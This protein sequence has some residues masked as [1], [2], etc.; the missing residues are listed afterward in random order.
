MARP[1]PFLN[2]LKD[3]GFLPLRLPR[4]DVAPLNMVQQHDKDLNLMGDLTSA[5]VP[6]AGVLPPPI[7]KD[8]QSANKLA[9]QKSSQVKLNIGL[10]ILGNIL[11]ALTGQN[12]GVSA[13]FQRASTLRFEFDDVMIDKVDAIKLD[14]FLSQ[15]DIN[16]A[17]RSIHDSLID[18]T[19]G[20]ITAVAKTKKYVVSA[21]KDD[22]TQAG[23]DVPVIQGVAGG[24]LKVDSSGSSNSE[25]TFE[26]PVPVAFGVQGVHISFSQEGKFTVFDPFQVGEGAVREEIKPK[27][28]VVPVA[29]ANLTSSSDSAAAL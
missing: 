6:H 2:L 18:G 20:V 11:Q 9:G 19:M 1:D 13:A 17:L 25:V 10:T 22:G 8:I 3:F 12:L 24:A 14:E 4:A 23:I 16:P 27:F 21:Q 7:I 26:G 29:F 15:S 28:I 5:M